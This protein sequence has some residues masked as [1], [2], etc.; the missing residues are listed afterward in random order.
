MQLKNKA[1]F[2]QMAYINGEWISA[3]DHKVFE[4]RNPFDNSIVATVADCGT[5]ETHQAIED[6]QTAFESWKKQTAEARSALLKNWHQLIIDNL[7][8]LAYLLTLEQGKPLF[9][10]IGEIKYGAS[11]IEW[12]AEEAKRAYGDVI[13]PQHSDVRITVIKQ[14]IGVVGA[15][16]PWNF[17]NAMITRK[18]APA[19]AAG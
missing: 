13:P 10:A 9:E 7:D 17:P 2:Q 18:V 6:A 16:T 19:L 12:F 15:I 11:F 14:P 8:D 5:Q 3:H 1:L 4:V